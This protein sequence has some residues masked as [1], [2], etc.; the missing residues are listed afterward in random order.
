MEPLNPEASLCLWTLLAKVKFKDYVRK[1][2]SLISEG[3]AVDKANEDP[4]ESGALG[5]CRGT[6]A[7]SIKLTLVETYLCCIQS[8]NETD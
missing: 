3:D 8:V 6:L 7:F 4:S 2:F 1:N 5:D